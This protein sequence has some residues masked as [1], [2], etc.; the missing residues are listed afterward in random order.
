VGKDEKQH[1]DQQN[2]VNWIR[3][4]R[5]GEKARRLSRRLRRRESLHDDLIGA[6]AGHGQEGAADQAGPM[7][8]G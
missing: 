8:F 3:T 1:S 5:H 7:L 4:I 6:M 2:T